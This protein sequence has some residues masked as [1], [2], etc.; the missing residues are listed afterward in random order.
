MEIELLKKDI[1]SISRLCEKM[2]VAIDKIQQVASDLSR[3]V[4]L[5][6]QKMQIQEKINEEV[7]NILEKQQKEHKT[8]I[9]ELNEKINKIETTILDELQN[10]KEDLSKK[11]GVIEAWRYTV[12]GAIALATWFVAQA[13]GLA[14][15]F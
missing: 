1:S 12:M 5:Q 6:E 3:I 10:V 9:K 14:K 15:L 11:I 2:D 7:E 13:L 8:D 4:S